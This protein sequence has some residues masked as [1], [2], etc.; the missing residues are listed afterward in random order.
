MLD[1]SVLDGDDEW[2]WMVESADC[3]RITMTA[4]DPDHIEV[5]L[6]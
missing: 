1:Q 5:V 6:S 4:I 2:A 3:A